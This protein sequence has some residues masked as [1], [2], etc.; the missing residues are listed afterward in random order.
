VRSAPVGG[1]V[2]LGR[3][4]PERWSSLLPL[5]GLVF[6]VLVVVG[7]PVLQ[8][9]TP[10]A[11]ASGAHVIAFYAAH[12]TRERLSDILLALAFAFFLLFAASLR[13]H[14]RR[15]ASAEAFATLVLAAAA[16]LVAGQTAGEGIGFALANHPTHLGPGAAQ[17]LNVLEN[18]AV[19]TSSVGFLVFGIAAGL[20]ILAGAP[21]PRWLGW[22]AI[23]IGILFVTPAEGIAAGALFLWILA[24]SIVIWR[25]GA[26]ARAAR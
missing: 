10:D 25:S 1:D 13:G 8:G 4:A 19:L 21:L 17:A 23:V 22:T 9:S 2:H 3:N 5:S 11:S 26:Q 20:A 15:V 6:G 12:R 24:V 14:L 18:G 16:V 7:G